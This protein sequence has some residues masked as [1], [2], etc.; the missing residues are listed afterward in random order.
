[1]G[2]QCADAGN[3]GLAHEHFQRG[4]KLYDGLAKLIDKTRPKMS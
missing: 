4:K 3:I 1:M 2:G